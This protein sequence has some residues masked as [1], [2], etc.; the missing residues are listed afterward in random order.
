M[1]YQRTDRF[2]ADYRSLRP[3]ER[4]Q[5]KGAVRALNQAAGTEQDPHQIAWPSRLR[6]K[7]VNSAPGVMEMTW[8]FSGPDGRATFELTRVDGHLGVRWR[9]LDGL[10][11]IAW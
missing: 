3:A 9:R 5:F 2:K 10:V 8:S 7:D 6:I 11:A 1:R 4:E